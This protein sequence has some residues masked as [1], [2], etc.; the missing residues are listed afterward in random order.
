MLFPRLAAAARRN[1]MLVLACAAPCT[2]SAAAQAQTVRFIHTAGDDAS[3]CT[4]SAPCRTLA[5]GLAAAPVRGEVRLLDSGSFGNGVTIAKSLTISGQGNTLILAG[6]ITVNA[7]AAKVVFRDLLLNGRGITTRGINVASA[8]AVHISG[9][10]IERFTQDGVYA[11][12]GAAELFVV[13]SVSRNNG[14]AGMAVLGGEAT[15]DQSRFENNVGFGLRASNAQTA[16]TRSAFSGNGTGIGQNGGTVSVIGAI[17]S[18]N[19]EFGY[20]VDG[21]GAM[22]LESSTA[23]GNGSAGL[24]VAAGTARISNMTVTH[25]TVGVDNAGTVLSRGTSTVFENGKNFQGNAVETLAG[26]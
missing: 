13:D 25:N 2:L 9:C 24:E 14:G 15:V 21:S 1:L 18:D 5:R 16:V 3:A 17:A 10:E 19:S 26:T 22:A 23:L 11:G 4:L 20:S 6:P 12:P 8:A 7:S